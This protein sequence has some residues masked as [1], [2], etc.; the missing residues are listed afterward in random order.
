[1]ASC[2]TDMPVSPPLRSRHSLP[3]ICCGDHALRR[4]PVTRSRKTGSASSFR[5]LGR[6]RQDRAR[7]SALCARYFPRP[8]CRAISR[9]TTD[10]H[11]PIDTA[12]SFCSAPLASPREISSRSAN[13]RTLRRTHPPI[14]HASARASHSPRIT[15]AKIP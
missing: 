15:Y 11:R 9:D 4:S 10:S 13:D 12:M 7:A 6:S 5:H 8:P 14:A 2:D 3:E 1:M